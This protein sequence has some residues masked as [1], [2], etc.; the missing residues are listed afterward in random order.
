MNNP[1]REMLPD[2]VCAMHGMLMNTQCLGTS[3]ELC[4]CTPDTHTKPHGFRVGTCGCVVFSVV[5]AGAV[6]RD[7]RQQSLAARSGVR[8]KSDQ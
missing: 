4:L 1:I 2:G 3:C 6:V 5:Q 8:H 7:C